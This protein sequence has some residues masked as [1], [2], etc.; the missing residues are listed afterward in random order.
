MDKLLK[1]PTD[2][3]LLVA[4]FYFVIKISKQFVFIPIVHHYFTD[5]LFIPTQLL[6]CLIAVRFLKQ[7]QSITIPFWLIVINVVLMSLLFEW[8]E[9]MVKNNTQQTA[10]VFDVVM[11]VLGGILYYLIQKTWFQRNI[12]NRNN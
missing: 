9:P 10:D 12:E 2:W 4:I 1:K 7:N 3:L 5:L 11:Y 6:I 8:Y